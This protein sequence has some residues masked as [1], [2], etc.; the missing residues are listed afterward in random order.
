MSRALRPETDTKQHGVHNM[1]LNDR[2]RAMAQ[3]I[4]RRHPTEETQV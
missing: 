3:A 2:G 4:I 1:H